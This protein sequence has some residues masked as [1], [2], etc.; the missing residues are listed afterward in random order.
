M[1][2]RLSAH[3]FRTGFRAPDVEALDLRCSAHSLLA[4]TAPCPQALV[5]SESDTSAAVQRALCG[6]FRSRPSA[7]DPAPALPGRDTRSRVPTFA[8]DVSSAPAPAPRSLV[9]IREFKTPGSR[10]PRTPPAPRAPAQGSLAAGTA[11]PYDGPCVFR[12][13]P[14]FVPSTPPAQ[15]SVLS[16]SS[17]IS[18][19]WAQTSARLVT[20]LWPP[21]PS[22]Y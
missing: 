3:A 18:Q 4:G 12:T 19:I 7:D 17:S 15:Y 1:T 6:R 8:A 13:G 10:A 16:A 20:C 5:C 22:V 21:N 14:S 11:R 9:L 2:P